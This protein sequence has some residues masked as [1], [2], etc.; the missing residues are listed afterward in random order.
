MST[1]VDIGK[2]SWY[3]QFNLDAEY[4]ID[5]ELFNELWD[6]HPVEYGKVKMMNYKT[7]KYEEINTPRWQQ[8]FG[9]DYNFTGMNHKASKLEH[10]YLIKLLKFVNDRSDL[11]YNQ[12]LINWYNDGQHYIG[13]HSDD[14]RQL[15]KNSAIYSFSFGQER[16]FVIKNKSYKVTDP[17]KV[18]I[19]IPLTNNSCVVMGGKMQKHFTHE[20]P[21]RAPSKCP[22]KRINITMRA[23]V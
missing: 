1:R 8:S 12:V 17:N 19:V 5:E 18:R 2:E 7:K 22:G 6:L 16:D 4:C 20:V 13:A 11:E 10:P 21:K 3:E 9:K 15:V 14:E 23:F